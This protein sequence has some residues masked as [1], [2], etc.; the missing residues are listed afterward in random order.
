MEFDFN[1]HNYST[2]SMK[3]EK[4]KVVLAYD[5]NVG[6]QTYGIQKTAN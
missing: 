6:L 2:Y 1:A 3:H 5:V 4:F